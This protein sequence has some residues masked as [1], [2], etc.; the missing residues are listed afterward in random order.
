M[1]RRPSSRFSKQSEASSTMP[2]IANEASEDLMKSPKNE[3]CQNSDF[4][5]PILRL[6]SEE[7]LK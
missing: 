7:V 5:F 3:V 1:K 4:R 6:D 2:E